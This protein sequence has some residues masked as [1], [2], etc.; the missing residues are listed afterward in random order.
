MTL[1]RRAYEPFTDSYPRIRLECLGE[2]VDNPDSDGTGI[3][4]DRIAALYQILPDRHVGDRGAE[5]LAIVVPI[6][7]H[8]IA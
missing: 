5:D 2:D 3:L 7:E 1:A 8:R 6:D 4:R